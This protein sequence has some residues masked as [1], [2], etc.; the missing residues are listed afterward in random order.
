MSTLSLRKIKHDSSAV[1]NIVTNSDGGVGIGDIDPSTLPSFIHHAAKVMNG[2]GIGIQ[3]STSTDNRWIFFGSGTSSGDVQQAGILNQGSDGSIHLTTAGTSRL[4]MNAS[5]Y[6]TLPYQ[7]SFYAHLTTVATISVNNPIIFN[8]EV[9]DTA[10]NYNT[11]NG[12]FTAP[13]TGLYQFNIS[14]LVDSSQ[15]AP[16]DV[17]VRIRVNGSGIPVSLYQTRRD[18][19][20]YD[21]MSKSFCYKLS[22]NDYIDVSIGGSTITIFG[23]GAGASDNQTSFSGYLVG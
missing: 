3:S 8:N 15:S 4:K 20:G 14:L 7:P 9:F 6:M 21:L 1:D 22:A 17:N 16:V 12:R 11:S 13:V 23:N 19:A 18:S 10:G 2:G 5:G